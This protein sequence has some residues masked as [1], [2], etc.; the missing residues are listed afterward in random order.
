MGETQ[1]GNFLTRLIDKA[2]EQGFS[3]IVMGVAC[4]GMYSMIIQNNKDVR[5]DMQEIREEL[6]ECRN[7]NRQLIQQ[8]ISKDK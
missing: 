1:N 3:F 2:G 6:T 8:L 4:W 5:D 7:Y